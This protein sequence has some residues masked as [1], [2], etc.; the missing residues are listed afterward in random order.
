MIVGVGCSLQA[1]SP[2]E[3]WAAGE[4]AEFEGIFTEGELLY[5]AGKKTLDDPKTKRRAGEHFAGRYAAKLALCKAAG[6][7]PEQVGDL[8]QI[9]VVRAPSGKPDLVLSQTVRQLLPTSVRVHLSITH[10]GDMAMAMVVLDRVG[11][12]S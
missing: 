1:V 9:E 7:R 4:G 8:R 5:S 10:S 2:L 12:S 3:R 11:A 6:L